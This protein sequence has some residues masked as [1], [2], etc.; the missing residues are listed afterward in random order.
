MKRLAIYGASGHGKVVAEIAELNG[1]DDIVFFD[2]ASENIK[3]N[4]IWPVRGDFEDLLRYKSDFDAVVVAI[5][6]NEV[7]IDRSELLRKSGI[8]LASLIHPSAIVSHYSS[9]GTGTVIMAKAVVNPFVA[10]GKDVIINSGA[11]VEH[12]CSI[13]NGVHVC[14]GVSLAGEVRVGRGAWVGIGATV[15]QQRCIGEQSIIGAGSVVIE[16]IPSHATACGVP[17]KLIK[18]N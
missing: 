8:Q 13:G 12:D 9:L 5:G 11:I 3:K 7:R 4:G 2:Q 1:W 16:D 10:I 15:I 17:T 14:P 18:S 6:N